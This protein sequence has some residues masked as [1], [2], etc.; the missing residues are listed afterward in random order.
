ME[1]PTKLVLSPNTSTESI[2]DNLTTKITEVMSRTQASSIID[3]VTVPTNIKLNDS[4]YALWSQVVEM[5]ISGK[6][7]LGC[8]NGDLP[9]PPETDPSFRL[10]REIDFR[11]PNLMQCAMDIQNYNSILQEERVYIFLDGLDDKLDNIKSD[12]L[13][14]KPFPTIEQAYAYVQ[15]EDTRQTVMTSSMENASNGAVMATK[16]VKSRHSHKGDS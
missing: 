13:Q 2:L 6:D 7:K 8:I 16:G 3:S 1:D 11:R 5:Y 10:W 14:L 4:N 12:V 15:R 9:K